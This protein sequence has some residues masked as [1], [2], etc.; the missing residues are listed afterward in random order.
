MKFFKQTNLPCTTDIDTVEK[1]AHEHG[2]EL[3][4]CNE[5]AISDL[6]PEER[7]YIGSETQELLFSVNA[8]TSDAAQKVVDSIRADLVNWPGY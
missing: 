5:A 2:A 1:I 4:A 7:D 3:L 6:C 8:R